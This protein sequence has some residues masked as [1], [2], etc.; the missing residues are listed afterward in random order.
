M[1][2]KT[3]IAV[4]GAGAAGCFCAIELKRLHPGL[5]VSLFEAGRVPMAK[6]ALT[7][8]GRCNLTNSFAGVDNLSE[9]YP[10]GERLMKRALK[11]FGPEDTMRWFEREGFSVRCFP[12]I[13]P[14]GGRRIS[15]YG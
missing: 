10:R 4:I 11:E 13:P 2:T 7:G 8:G 14:P 1:Q 9:V 15:R 12:S 3:D 5:S 6:L